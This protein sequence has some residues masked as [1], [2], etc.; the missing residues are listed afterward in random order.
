MENIV[1]DTNSLVVSVSRKSRNYI[2]WKKFIDGEY[3]LCVTTEILEEYSEILSAVTTPEISNNIIMA[4]LNRPNTRRIETYYNFHLIE[5]AP[6]DNK[7]VDCAIAANAR[8][9]VTDDRHYKVLEKID[10]PKVP[11]ISIDEFAD[12]LRNLQ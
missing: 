8:F 4:I 12:L 7:F 11:C 9:I 2:I 3:V 1:L 10:F 5:D 6:D